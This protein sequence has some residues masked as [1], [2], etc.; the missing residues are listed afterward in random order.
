MRKSLWLFSLLA[1]A[2]CGGQQA[3]SA[4]AQAGPTTGDTYH[5]EGIKLTRPNDWTFVNADPS[6]APDTLII[7]QG[8]AGISPTAPVVEVSRRK[9]S[10]IDQRKKPISILSSMVAEM[11]QLFEGFETVGSPEEVQVAGTPASRLSLKYTESM[12]DGTE[13]AHAARFYGIVRGDTIWVIRCIGPA[14]GSAEGACENI[15]GSIEFGS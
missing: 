2:G 11:A 9:L 15:V 5:N 6:V 1:L 8:P 12:P 7:V 3:S 13:A 4:A 10:A 14:D